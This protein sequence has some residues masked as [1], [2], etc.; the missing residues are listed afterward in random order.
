MRA[1][2]FL[3]RELHNVLLVVSGGNRILQVDPDN[4][5]VTVILE[6]GLNDFITVVDSAVSEE[7]A[8]LTV[9]GCRS[10][11]LIIRNDWE[12]VGKVVECGAEICDL[13][14]SP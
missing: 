10:G 14:I 3:E 9:C 6:V 4:H 1:M 5:E 13:K 11:K 8:G 7:G 12:E 2:C